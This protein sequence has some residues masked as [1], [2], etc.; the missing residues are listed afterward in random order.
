MFFKTTNAANGKGLL[1]NADHI[2][3]IEPTNR[4]VKITF[5][6][7]KTAETSADFNKLE[8]MLGAVV[9]PDGAFPD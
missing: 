7:G 5:E 9:V 4:G 8:N 3:Q 1:I 6:S 2:D